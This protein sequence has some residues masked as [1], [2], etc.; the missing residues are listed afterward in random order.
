MKMTGTH[1][2]TLVREVLKSQRTAVV[3]RDSCQD[4]VLSEKF[5]IGGSKEELK[6]LDDVE[7]VGDLL[8]IIE[9]AVQIKKGVKGAAIKG[10]GEAI[11]D[12]FL[13]K[14][15]GL[16]LGKG[17][18]GVAKAAYK[19]P[20]DVSVGKGLKFLD[21]DDDIGTIVD[22]KVENAFLLAVQKELSNLNPDKP[23]SD[24]DMNAALANYLKKTFNQRTVAGFA[25]K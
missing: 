15:P 9:A 18:F 20:D 19:L 24:L 4:S 16:Q 10:V 14:L 6:S 2:R 25:G 23:L 3:L 21:I 11:V 1:L 17:L 7:T 13:G 8:A 22:D 12:E 5:G